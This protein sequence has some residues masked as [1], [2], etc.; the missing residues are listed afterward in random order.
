MAK[1]KIH[2]V[3]Y[4]FLGL[5]A[6]L[7]LFGL[8]MLYSASTVESYKNFGNTSHY[9][10]HQLV[11]GAGLGLIAMYICSRIDYHFWQ[12]AIPVLLIVSLAALI[13]VKVPGISFSSGGASRWIH[14]G[15][16]F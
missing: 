12:K 14:L 2:R 3:D 5:I 16:L 1:T 8:A 11:Y 13:M 4:I 10:V 7:V 9:F 6:A 15:P